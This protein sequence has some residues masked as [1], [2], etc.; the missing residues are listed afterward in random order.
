MAQNQSVTTPQDTPISITVRATDPDN[1]RLTYVIVSPP[2]NG[3][4]TG[5]GNVR[6]YTPNAGFIGSDSFTFKANDGQ[7]DSNIATVNITVTAAG[8]AQ[9]VVGSGLLQGNFNRALRFTLNVTK[10]ARGVVGGSLAISDGR[11]DM[12]R[13]SVIDSLTV[14]G[15]TAT[16]TGRARRG[17]QNYSFTLLVSDTSTGN[18]TFKLRASDGVSFSGRVTA[19]SISVR[20]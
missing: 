13:S 3:K 4:L 16:I 11:G 5:S 9:S 19:G 7:A 6:T 2:R 15:N 1:D 10:S 14:S 20:P 17:R 12:V 18:G 8:A